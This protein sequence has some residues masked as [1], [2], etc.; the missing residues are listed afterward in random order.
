MA[1]VRVDKWLWAVRLYKHRTSAT[2]AAKQGHVKINGVVVKASK[3]VTIGDKVSAFTPGGARVVEVVKCS[4]VRGPA[5]VAVTM[6][7]DHTPPPDPKEAFV[8]EVVRA[9]GGGRPTK[10]DARMLRKLKHGG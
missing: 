10:R 8:A 6:Y 5:A 7:V 1:D 9:R 3:C 4:G 2:T